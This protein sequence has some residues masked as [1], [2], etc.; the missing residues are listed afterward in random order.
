M[1]NKKNKGFSMVEIL[2]SITIFMILMIPIVSALFSGIKRTTSGKELQYR[3]DFAQNLME[4][5]KEDSINNVIM[6]NYYSSIGAYDIGTSSS[7]GTVASTITGEDIPFEKHYVQGSMNL[8]TNHTKYSYIM[9]VSNEYYATKEAKDDTYVNPNNLSLGVVEDLDRDKVALI[10]GT[11][12]NYDEAVS[13]AFMTKKIQILKDNNPEK[14]AQYVSQIEVA[15]PFSNDGVTR[16][17]KVVVSGSKTTGYEVSCKLSYHDNSTV[18]VTTG[19]SMQA[20]QYLGDYN[21]EYTPYTKKFDTLPN[22]YLMYNTCLYN[23]FYSPNDYI[24]Y[25]TSGVTDDTPVNVFVVETASTY[26]TNVSEVLKED[27]NL[28]SAAIDSAILY[29][30]RISTGTGVRDAVRIVMAVTKDTKVSNLSVFHNFDPTAQNT[31]KNKKNQNLL[32]TGI[33]DLDSTIYKPLVNLNGDGGIVT[34]DSAKVGALSEAQEENR[35]L[36]QVRIWMAEG[37][38]GAVDTTKN[39]IITGTKGGDES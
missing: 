25:D 2:I 39:P 13:N 33:L 23:G 5:V 30:N 31:D 36:Y 4:Y 28:D 24:V 26:S 3:N 22:I 9:E 27:T 12:A 1:V 6:P 35:G 7:A 17:I 20:P 21:I 14:Y 8:G 15:N 38:I 16:I 19:V 10:D 37:D 32:T 18:E 29:N 11:I 34:A